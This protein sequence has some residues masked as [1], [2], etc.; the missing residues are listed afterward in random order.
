MKSDD[1]TH[2]T[3]LVGKAKSGDRQAYSELVKL[4]MNQVV[5]F[6]YRMTQDKDSALDLAQETFLAAWE[7]L[8]S[9]R[10]DA[11]F[12]TWLHRIAANK[13]L[14]Y[15]KKAKRTVSL[16]DV[17]DETV[18]ST[19]ES[20][21]SDVQMQREQLRRHVLGFMSTLPEQQRLVFDLRFYKEHSFNE[22][23]SITGRALG[24]VK[25]NY[26]EAVTKL[27]EFAREKGWR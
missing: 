18:G 11:Q 10:G 4:K 16:G 12:S 25:T 23:A 19:V 9:Y 8:S 13:T 3:N 20:S 26:R 14:N 27:R 21:G 5:A 17:A 24:T 1:N 15:L 22:I 7:S 6:A 2:I